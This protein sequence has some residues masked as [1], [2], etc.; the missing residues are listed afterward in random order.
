[1]LVTQALCLLW[2]LEDSWRWG[3]L[4]SQLAILTF[5]YSD[6]GGPWVDS[7]PWTLHSRIATYTHYRPEPRK[8]QPH[9]RWQSAQLPQ[10]PRLS[11]SG[12]PQAAAGFIQCP[13]PSPVHT[14]LPS[15]N[16]RSPCFSHYPTA[17]GAT[18]QANID[19]GHTGYAHSLAHLR[20][21]IDK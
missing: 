15:S 18:G 16:C 3:G 6:S 2:L 1:M 17:P 21:E 19:G 8:H 13:S 10:S 4:R 7:L 20:W 11:C 5:K 12:K 14:R 9:R